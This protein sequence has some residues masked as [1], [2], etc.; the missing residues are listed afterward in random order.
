MAVY[1]D[2]DG[3][4]FTVQSI[5]LLHAAVLDDIEFLIIDNHPDGPVAEGLRSLT[6]R[7]PRCRY[8]PFGGFHSTAVRDL[9]FREATTEYVL[10]LDA[11]VLLPAGTLR[12]LLDYF[13]AHPDSR[14]LVQGPMLSDSLAGLVAR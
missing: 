11:H 2:Y 1:D 7:V 9:V 8:V 13:Q 12:T 14:D 5:R 4:Y 6:Q 3:A 10:C